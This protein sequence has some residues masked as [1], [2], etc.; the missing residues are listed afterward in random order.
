MDLPAG[1]V[2]NI[3]SR[4]SIKTIGHCGCVCKK[5]HNL[6]SETY[7]VSL[8]LSRSPKGLIVHRTKRSINM[9]ELDDKFDYHD[10]INSD[11]WTDLSQ[12]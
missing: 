5:W 2:A 11:L 6:L 4:L 7:F 10:I 8:H 3:L 9:G 1:I 12:S